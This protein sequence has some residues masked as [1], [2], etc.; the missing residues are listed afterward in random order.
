MLKIILMLISLVPLGCQL[1][2]LLGAW[3]GSRLDQFDWIFYLFTVGAAVWAVYREKR[4]KYDW[5]AL[6]LLIPMVILAL[7]PSLHNINALSVASSVMVIFAVVW[8]VYAWRFAGRIL[9]VA[10]IMLLGTPSSSYQLSLLLMCP[11]WAAWGIKFLLALGALVWIWCNK[12]FDWQIKKGTLF[13][14]AAVLG[15]CMLLIHTKEI[16]FEGKSFI[17]EFPVHVGDYWGRSIQ[18]DEN[19]R[20]FFATSKVELYRYTKDN[21]DISVLAV[22]CG[23]DIHEIHPAS[24]CLRTS[25][26]VVNSEKILYLQDNFA[27]TEIDATKGTSRCLVWVWFSCEEFSTPGFL[28]FRR[29]F[30]ENGNYYT[31]Q[32]S[33]PVYDSVEK[34]RED[35]RNFVSQLN[36]ERQ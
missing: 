32:I 36:R 8:L 33:I 6:I 34:S 28:G 27:V 14:L 35:L 1:P 25:S 10:L 13:F 24:H 11:V 3:S 31:Y 22:K 5:Y 26:W 7:V 4:G 18:P 30:K 19:T 9:P 16:Y 17:P 21:V 15:S 29:H 23:G 20:R 12:H 2:Y